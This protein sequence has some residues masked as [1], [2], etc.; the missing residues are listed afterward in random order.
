MRTKQFTNYKNGILKDNF[1]RCSR[2][3]RRS[4]SWLEPTNSAD[5][6]CSKHYGRWNS[7]SNWPA[8]NW[9][10][11]NWSTPNRSTSNWPASNRPSNWTSLNWSSV[12]WNTKSIRQFNQP[13]HQQF[14][15]IPRQSS[16]LKFCLFHSGPK[17]HANKSL[18]RKQDCFPSFSLRL[19]ANSA[20][21]LHS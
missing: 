18:N 2:G 12:C 21:H 6:K 15:W 10:A 20:L 19:K 9:P 14:E 4:S 7:S 13:Y 16:S 1:L 11:S 5:W 17:M 3:I 8:S